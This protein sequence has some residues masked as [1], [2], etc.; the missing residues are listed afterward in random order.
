MPVLLKRFTTIE[1]IHL[2]FLPSV[3]PVEA[4]SNHSA[5]GTE[6]KTALVITH[7]GTIRAPVTALGR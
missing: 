5:G 2:S 4:T 3:P 7:L 1:Q 6:G